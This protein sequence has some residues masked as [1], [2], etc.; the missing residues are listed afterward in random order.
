MSARGRYGI[1]FLIDLAENV[2][3]DHVTLAS[4]AARKEISQRYME[5]VVVILHRTG[6]IRSIKGASGG[7]TLARPPEQINIGEALRMLEGDL[8][9]V[10]PVDPSEETALERCIRQT[11]FDPLNERIARVTD[12]KTLA[13]LVGTQDPDESYMY[14]I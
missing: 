4:A 9:V 10:D 1:Q 2:G 6:F 7:Y 11:I 3:Q 12:S 8:L 5:Q 14:F 13:D